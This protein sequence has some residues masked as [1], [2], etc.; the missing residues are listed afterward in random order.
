MLDTSAPATAGNDAVRQC[1][2][3]PA[4]SS[5]ALPEEQVP[6]G[7]ICQPYRDTS[8]S[9]STLQVTLDMQLLTTQ[10]S[11]VYFFH[12]RT[13]ISEQDTQDRALMISSDDDI[14]CIH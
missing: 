11:S 13:E 12:P 5:A 1:A 6:T 7:C 8:V 2:E 3:Y 14:R 4:W 9:P 10:L